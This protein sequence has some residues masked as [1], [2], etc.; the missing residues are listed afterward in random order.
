M[1]RIALLMLALS[2]VL[3]SQVSPVSVPD[4]AG[5]GVAASVASVLPAQGIADPGTVRFIQFVAPASNTGTVRVGD[6]KISTTR[7]IPLAA[8]AG[9]NAPTVCSGSINDCKTYTAAW[10]FLVAAGDKVSIVIGR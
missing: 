6:S 7:G 3:F 8:G 2:V 10:Y 9:H 4:I 1:K 5:T